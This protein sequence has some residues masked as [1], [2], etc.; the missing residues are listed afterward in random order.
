MAKKK[1]ALDVP[2][3]AFLNMARQYHEAAEELF[4]AGERRASVGGQRAI[5]DPTYFL[6]FH[7]MELA[8]K[9][10]R[11]AHGLPNWNTHK[12]TE[13]YKDCQILGL[14]IE[15]DERFQIKGLVSLLES[16]EEYLRFRYVNPNSTGQ[17]D[18]A[19]TR[20][21]VDAVI[22]NVSDQMP[23]S[24]ISPKGGKMVVSWGKLLPKDDAKPG[25]IV[26][27]V[28]KEIPKKDD[29]RI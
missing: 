24:S 29:S 3:M 23:V 16:G 22:Q 4:A 10:Y 26:F 7:T 2:A 11:R 25:K 21:G 5:T 20:E 18:L 14:A 1:T 28:G 12:L 9:A 6:Y 15:P 27:T 19:W 8:F 13:L 17:P